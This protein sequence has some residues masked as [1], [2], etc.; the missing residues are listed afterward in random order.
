VAVLEK[1]KIDIDE[2][3]TEKLGDLNEMESLFAGSS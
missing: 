1:N 2:K 3:D